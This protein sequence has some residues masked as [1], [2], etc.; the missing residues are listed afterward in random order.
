M[1]TRSLVAAA[2]FCLALGLAGCSTQTTANAEKT[3]TP[4]C[5]GD[6]AKADK[7]CCKDAAASGK[8]PACCSDSAAAKK[9]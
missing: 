4:A 2:A 7:D 3:A 5:C 1:T 9:N 6:S 8:T